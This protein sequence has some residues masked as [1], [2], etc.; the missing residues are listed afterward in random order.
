MLK[1]GDASA[2]K[3]AIR[4]RAL[5]QAADAMCRESADKDCL[6]NFIHCLHVLSEALGLL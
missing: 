4:F 2:R 1:I 6:P 3:V 5:Q